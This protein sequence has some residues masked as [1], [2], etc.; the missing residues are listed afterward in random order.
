V[1]QQDSTNQS[2]PAPTATNEN[3]A[4][5]TS[6]REGSLFGVAPLFVVRF[7][8]AVL[9]ASAPSYTAPGGII[10]SCAAARGLDETAT[11]RL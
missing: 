10:T 2:D 9:T 5:I 1:L 3:G 8:S 4:P 11:M 7:T 6:S